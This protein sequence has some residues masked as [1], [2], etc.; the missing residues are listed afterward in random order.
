MRR[1]SP[2]IFRIAPI[3]AALI[4]LSS[5]A[6]QQNMTTIYSLDGPELSIAGEQEEI[7]FEG[8][9]ERLSMLG[10]GNV[11]FRRM[12]N[13][14]DEPALICEGPIRATPN[15]QGHLS[16]GLI[17]SNQDILML[18]FRA[19]GPDQ[20]IGLGRFIR[21]SESNSVVGSALLF[22]FHP[23]QEE[24]RRRLDQ[25]KG[26]LLGIISKGQDK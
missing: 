21:P 26:A 18:T 4:L 24:A 8:S 16:A 15:K 1:S 20:G 14:E 10:Q 9:M 6:V 11:S 19:L 7:L 5:C 2:G 12:D 25:E 13:P 22:Y 3:M 23:W 17:C